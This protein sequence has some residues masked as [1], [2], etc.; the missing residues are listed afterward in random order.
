MREHPP[1]N[2]LVQ[3]SQKRLVAT[4]LALVASFAMGLLFQGTM[5]NLVVLALVAAAWLIAIMCLGA[6]GMTEAFDRN[7]YG[8]AFALVMLSYLVVLYRFSISPDSSFA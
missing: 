4:A 8:V 3:V 6:N 7:R 2:Q 1:A 5:T